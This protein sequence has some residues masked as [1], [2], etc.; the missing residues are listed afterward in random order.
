MVDDGKD[1]TGANAEVIE[2]PVC[3]QYT[4]QASLF[5]QAIRD[6][7]DQEIPLEHAIRN[8]AVIDAVFRSAATGQ[9]EEI[10]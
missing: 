6:N 8:M 4:I 7:R 5:S 2:L 9:W 10:H 1:L 3:D